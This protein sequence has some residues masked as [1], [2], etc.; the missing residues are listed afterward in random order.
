[1]AYWPNSPCCGK[2]PCKIDGRRLF[3]QVIRLPVSGRRQ[4]PPG[5]MKQSFLA[6]PGAGAYTKVLTFSN[7]FA[8]EI[9]ADGYA[10]DAAAAV[11]LARNLVKKG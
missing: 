2:A 9:G 10:Q 6:P 4:A 1:M 5:L 8:H 3:G 11:P 7:L